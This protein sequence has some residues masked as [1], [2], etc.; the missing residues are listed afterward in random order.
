MQP[1]LVLGQ[2]DE[3][4]HIDRQAVSAI[5]ERF[6]RSK[7]REE[8]NA[9]RV[10]QTRSDYLAENATFYSRILEPKGFEALI[11][12][13]PDRV[14][15]LP[16]TARRG[17]TRVF[18]EIVNDRDGTLCPAPSP[19]W[20]VPMGELGAND[21]YYMLMAMDRGNVIG[22][23][24]NSNFAFAKIFLEDLLH[25]NTFITRALLDTVVISD[26]IP[27][28]LGTHN[29]TEGYGTSDEDEFVITDV[30]VSAADVDG[31]GCDGPIDTTYLYVAEDGTR[32]I[33]RIRFPT[34][35]DAGHMVARH[36]PKELF[37][38]VKEF[39][40]APETP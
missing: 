35:R 9:Y 12:T 2:S 19:D 14:V 10:D 39:L 28:I 24:V 11:G 18:D 38:E 23:A 34:Y 37:D 40:C 36:S 7:R 31:V 13:A 4:E 15:G 27:A 30:T 29:A 32:P 16:S 26:A 1:A 25:V 33:R 8:Y 17:V 6:S 5:E 20:L 22:S 3:L 21:C